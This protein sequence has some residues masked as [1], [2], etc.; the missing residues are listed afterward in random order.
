MTLSLSEHSR[1]AEAVA[2]PRQGQASFTER[3]PAV[4]VA[5]ADPSPTLATVVLGDHLAQ[6]EPVWGCELEHVV[7]GHHRE[8]ARWV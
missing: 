6:I 1:A 4:V 5:S 8:C 2:H 7:V 3:G